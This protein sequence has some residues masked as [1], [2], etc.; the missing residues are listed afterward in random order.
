[1]EKY[2][3]IL[4]FYEFIYIANQHKLANEIKYFCEN[5]NIR[6]VII[7]APEGINLTVAGLPLSI[8]SFENFIK[9]RN[10]KNYHPKYATSDIMP[11][12]RLK[13]KTKNEIIT[14]LDR[15]IDVDSERGVLVD[16]T[17]WNQIIID[18]E[19]LLL[20]VRNQFEVRLGSFNNSVSP[21]TSSFT[22]FKDYVD[23]V[24]EHQKTKKIA[25]FCTGGIRCEKAS[26]YMK[27]IGF[28]DIYQLNGGILNYLQKISQ[29]DS[30]WN[31]ECFVFDNR[32]SVDHD[33]KKGTYMLCRGCNNP[34]SITETQSPKY[35]KDV[36][37]PVCYSLA[38]DEKKNR[39][40]ERVKQID[41]SVS[42]NEVPSHVT[43]TVD[44]Y[45]SGNY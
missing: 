10:I 3:K 2:F 41:L 11:F 43:P 8:S 19:V 25:M 42:R 21:K 20:D 28:T 30:L 7:I 15:S 29:D 32:V 17:D 22:E 31:G 37:C 24:L 5:N 44:E 18:P 34:M 1:M 45:V 27:K 12:Y 26:Y 33:L 23:N 39:S 14:M 6:G 35:E 4:A 9:S 36:S 40:R 13:V 38:S 16:P